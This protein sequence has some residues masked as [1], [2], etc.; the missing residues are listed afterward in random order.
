MESRKKRIIRPYEVILLALIGGFLLYMGMQTLGV[1]PTSRSEEVTWL[2]RPTGPESPITLVNEE[3]DQQVNATIENIA[4]QFVE[5]KRRNRRTSKSDLRRKGLSDDEAEYL[6]DVQER[7]E[8][9]RSAGEWVETIKTSYDTY[10]TVKS[11]FDRVDGRTDDYV[12]DTEVDQILSD[13]ELKNRTFS[14]IERT[15]NIARPQLEA[16]AKRGGGALNDWATFVD[17]NRR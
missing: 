12:P 2:D 3:R 13:P 4:V 1:S 14:N 8:E 17:Q 5:D 7:K 9:G 15:F 11:I 6:Q 10:K 16:F